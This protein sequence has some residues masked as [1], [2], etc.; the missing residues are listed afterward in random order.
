[1]RLDDAVRCDVRGCP[2]HAL[3]TVAKDE[4]SLTMCGHDFDVRMILLFADGWAVRH[5]TRPALRLAESAR[6]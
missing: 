5:D 1:M 2:A 6:R 4:L 3:V